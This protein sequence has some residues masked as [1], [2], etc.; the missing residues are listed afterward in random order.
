[1]VE[2][3]EQLRSIGS[4]RPLEAG[5]TEQVSTADERRELLERIMASE[6]PLPSRLENAVPKRSAGRARVLVA[7]VA[8]AVVAVVGAAVAVS[9][10]PT[11]G[12]EVAE[13]RPES[14][15]VE[16]ISQRTPAA[17]SEVA[18]TQRF[19]VRVQLADAA[20]VPRSKVDVA[21][22]P[23]GSVTRIDEFDGSG[24][25]VRSTLLRSL[26]SATA[27]LSVD[28]SSRTWTEYVAYD[29]EGI[30]SDERGVV[31][32]AGGVD[33]G[34][35]GVGWAASPSAL[36]ALLASGSLA[37]EEETDGVVRLSG[38]V[39]G[40]ASAGPVAAQLESLAPGSTVELWIDESS[41]LPSR[42]RVTDPV[43]AVSDAAVWWGGEDVG[44]QVPDGYERR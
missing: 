6:G 24:G 27:T 2:R 29:P 40:L 4:V 31:F 5:L 35:V 43:G 22:S 16:L 15:S 13:R 25:A 1:M 34:Q 9:S 3:S 12:S 28:H 36:E 30:S 44:L 32:V 17:V 18:S 8:G 20:G 10:D 39:S 23:D 14:V 37:V 7:S 33:V 26:G 42:I 41:Y 11:P 19:N 21:Q 38:G